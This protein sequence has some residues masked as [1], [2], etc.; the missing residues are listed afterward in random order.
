VSLLWVASLAIWAVIPKSL[1]F[2]YYYHLSG[3]WLCV[4]L[5]TAF[6]LH[7]TGK[8]A[9]WIEWYALGCLALFVHFY[10][11]ISAAALPGP[12][13]FNRWMWFPSWR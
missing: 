8:R 9:R 4:A 12:Q 2:Y 13:A 6:H 3:I 1:G 7:G 11:I 10:P 5:G